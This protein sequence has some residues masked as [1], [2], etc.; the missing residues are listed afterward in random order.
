VSKRLSRNSAHAK[1]IA[2]IKRART[3]RLASLVTKSYML[4][5]RKQDEK[6]YNLICEEFM[7]LGGVYVKFLQ[8]VLL[9]S[10]VMRKW[11]NPEKLKIF[12]NLD[13]EP[14]DIIKL[15]N[16]ELSEDKLAQI[17]L[18]QPQPFAAG[19]FGQVYYGQLASGQAIIIKVLRPMVRELLKYDIKLLGTFSKTFFVK[20]YKH[21]NV[22]ISDAFKEFSTA[23]L[24]ETDYKYEADFAHELYETYKDHPNMV[25][26]KTYLD[27]CTDNIIVQDYVDGISVAQIVRLHEQG[28]DPVLYVEQQLGSDLAKQMEILGYELMMAAFEQPRLQGDPHPGNVRL[29][30]D[31]KI[32]LID[33]GISAKAPEDKSNLFGLLEAYDKVFKGTQSAVGLLERG[34]RFFVSDLYRSLKSLGDYLSKGS[35]RDMVNEVSQVAGSV[36]ELATGSD[37]ISLDVKSDA[38]VLSVINKL[39]NKG[40]R[41]GIIMKLEATEILRAI[42][43]YTAMLSSLGLYNKV[44]PAIMDRS[45]RDIQ[46]RHPDIIRDDK[47]AVSVSDALETV[48]AW[49]E[50][51]AARDPM[52]FRQLSEKM[53]VTKPAI[54]PES[55]GEIENV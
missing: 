27:L 15:L 38:N 45:V 2:A 23:T 32:G 37:T 26:P 44:M 20:L 49:L 24:R 41:F 29:M 50:R 1:T 3:R 48:A 53:R 4:H 5:R 34:M 13:T 30:R 46:A 22:Q 8:G 39:V 54:I 51:I 12:E 47:E 36:F 16:H 9:R 28:V 31:N 52:L 55:E 40:N 42:Q 17:S 14:L 21:M 25:I 35:D 33:F 7:S 11:H 6:M 18:I 10:Q 19:S 43:T